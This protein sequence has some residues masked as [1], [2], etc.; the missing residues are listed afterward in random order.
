MKT[1]HVIVLNIVG[2]APEHLL[3]EDVLPNITGLLK[4]G[5]KAPLLPSFP[6][7]TCSVQSSIATGHYPE[8]HGII[9]NGLFIKD[10]FRIA[11]WEQASSLVQKKRIWDIVKERRPELKTALLFW[12][13]SLY[14]NSDIVVTPRP[15][16]TEK[17]LVQWCYSKPVGYYEEIVEATE[18]FDLKHYWGPLASFKS[19][20]WIAN[21]A[22]YTLK[23]HKP[24]LM[25]VYLPHMDYSC[26]RFGLEP[27]RLRQEL[28][29]VD[30]LVGR[31]LKTIEECG[32]R[33]DTTII[34]LSEY[35]FHEVSSSL[36][37]NIIL[38]NNGFLSVRK[39]GGKEYLDLECGR[40]FAMVDHQ[41]AH[42][43]INNSEDIERVKKLFLETE[44]IKYVFGQDEKKKHQ[45]ASPRSGDL[46]IVSDVDKWFNYYYWN[47]LELAPDFAFTVDIH[48]KPG[49]DPLELI[50][51]HATKTISLDTRLI[52][53]SHGFPSAEGDKMAAFFM[54]GMGAEFERKDVIETID[55]A[56]L[57]YSLLGIS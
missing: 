38:R 23:K 37:P 55:I 45:I 20:E 34:G 43:Y 40:A 50:F 48:N 29:N 27:Q 8:E 42:I 57:I 6:E 41:M 16:H 12:Q 56:P 47:S 17:G 26:Q 15:L 49:Y 32:M 1:K 22:V 14:A 28:E 2:L 18:P 3:M 36:S 11:F 31:I 4:N 53:G 9:A 5:F 46:I 52:K 51:D 24:N 54:S 21:A 25:F 13:N 39:I 30:E 35:P 19:S 10:E 33:D 7:V 44:G